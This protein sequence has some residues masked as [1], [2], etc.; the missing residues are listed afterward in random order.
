MSISGKQKT[1]NLSKYNKN[2]L[3]LDIFQGTFIHH[4][5][6]QLFFL[7]WKKVLFKNP[8]GINIPGTSIHI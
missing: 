7:E 6:E 2:F 1:A 4:Y 3:C 8:T 5:N